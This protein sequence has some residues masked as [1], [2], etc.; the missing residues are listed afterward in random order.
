LDFNDNIKNVK[1]I[2]A[3]SN[4]NGILSFDALYPNKDYSAVYIY[5]EIRS[6]HNQKCIFFLGSDDGVKVWLNGSLIH[7]NDVGRGLTPRE[8]KFEGELISGINR[9]LIKVTEYVRGWEVI[10][11]P[12]DSIGYESMRKDE[13]EKEDFHHYLN[14]N[15]S[16]TPSWEN[17]ITFYAGDKFPDL[18]WDKPY[19]IEKFA[20]DMKMNIK[21]FDSQLNEVQSPTN[22]GMYAYYAEGKSKDGNNIRKAA[23]LYAYP[24]DWM[25][26]S[27]APIA[28]LSYMPISTIDS[29]VWKSNQSVIGKY[30]GR[31]INTSSLHQGEASILIS[32]LDNQIKSDHSS[33][34]NTPI[35]FNGDY[36]IALKRKLLGVENRWP[37]FKLPQTIKYAAT[38]LS[39]ANETEAGFKIG[40]KK[41][42][43][44]LCTEWFDKSRE[45]F[46]ILVARNG[47]IVINEAFGSDSYGEFTIS[48]PSE[49]ASITKLL[50]GLLFAQ[51]VDQGLI[52]IDSYVGE[53]LPDFETNTDTSITLR[54]CFTH[55][56]GL[57]GHGIWGGVQNPWMDNTVANLLPILPVGKIYQYNGVGYN[58]AGKVMEIVSGK[59]IFRIFR[60]YLFDPLGMKN[61]FNE[62]DLAY[63][64][65]STAY[66]L[67]II[68]Q[69]IINKGSYGELKYFSE[70][71]FDKILP[72]PLN[73]WYPGIKQEWGIGLTWMRNYRSKVGNNGE[74]VGDVILS[75]NTIGHGS[76]TASILNVDL[77]NK[78]VITQSRRKAGNH[79]NE[80]LEKLLILLEENLVR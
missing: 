47:K 24:T 36:H 3:K 33:P 52:D 25:G 29:N 69:L 63:G 35:I 26:W 55:T 20:G 19:L 39:Y 70:G 7:S 38:E 23:T 43:K 32:F 64:T 22:P 5:S 37:K 77:D 54:N 9:L 80:Y 75:S 12:F 41:A 2:K 14:T 51:F 72:K 67:G 40:T 73:K 76:A 58:L 1:V 42:I 53:F 44:K 31:M 11:E 4:E 50:T 56:S 10:V 59:S 74:Q 48:T 68:G 27:E 15:L 45:P 30:V 71:T 34:L 8:D 49:I 62:E 60:E 66:D 21:W 65:H 79:Y 6:E 13:K 18:L 57:F 28:N 61:T 16:V 46:D 78:I 17:E